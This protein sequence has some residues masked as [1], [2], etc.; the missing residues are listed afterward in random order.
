M[1]LREGGCNGENRVRLIRPVSEAN[2]ERFFS[3]WW[4]QEDHV[5]IYENRS[6]TVYCKKGHRRE[7]QERGD[8]GY[9]CV[10]AVCFMYNINLNTDFHN[11]LAFW[12][13][14]V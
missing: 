8:R 5:C 11:S 12:Q 10:W 7:G 14:L 2:T 6:E 13:F 9:R 3:P 4:F 1:S